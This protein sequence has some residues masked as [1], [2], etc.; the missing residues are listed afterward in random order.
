MNSCRIVDLGGG[1]GGDGSSNLESLFVRRVPFTW[2]VR[3]K[4][5]RRFKSGR[6]KLGWQ[7]ISKRMN[8]LAQCAADQRGQGSNDHDHEWVPSRRVPFAVCFFRTR[9]WANFDSF[10]RDGLANLSRD[11]HGENTAPAPASVTSSSS[12]CES[13]IK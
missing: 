3:A 5:F 4:G 11:R 6:S 10:Q 8:R 13:L 12:P 7:C 9:G 2:D 1:G